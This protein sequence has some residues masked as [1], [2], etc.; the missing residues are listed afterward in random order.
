MV[1]MIKGSTIKLYELVAAGLD[2]FNRVIYNEVE[3]EVSNVIIQPASNDDIVSESEVNG[4]HVAYIL[5]IPKGD[6][7]NWDDATVEF[8]GCKWKTFGSAMIYDVNL[9]PLEWNKQ[10]KVER[11]E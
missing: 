2:D 3:T 8:Y 6:T 11:Y 9:T 7:H 5:H 10:V 4:K 1:S